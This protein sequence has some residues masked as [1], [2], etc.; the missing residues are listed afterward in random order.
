[1]ISCVAVGLGI[2]ILVVIIALQLLRRDAPK[3]PCRRCVGFGSCI[4]LIRSA[5]PETATSQTVAVLLFSARARRM[6]STLFVVDSFGRS[7]QRSLR[8][9]APGEGG[10]GSAAS[11]GPSRCQT[12]SAAP[13][14]L[15]VRLTFASLKTVDVTAQL[16]SR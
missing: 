16:D 8:V 7:H 4:A 12:F 6:S 1:L 11:L 9:S 13:S 10:G 15:L 5:R 14:L 2:V 3:P